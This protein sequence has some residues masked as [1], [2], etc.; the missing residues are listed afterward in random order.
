MIFTQ[1]EEV[2]KTIHEIVNH[3]DL[4]DFYA[5]GNKV[6][7]EQTIIQKEGN[8]VKPDRM[9]LNA[10]NEIYLLD[11]KTGSHLPKYKVQL[12]QYQNA[13]EAMGFKVVKK[14]LVYIGEEIDV[15]NL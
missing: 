7:N 2:T 15:V 12:D 9:V 10:N 1:K 4:I 14:S 11:Y 3:Y 8:L 13:I 5:Q 6:L